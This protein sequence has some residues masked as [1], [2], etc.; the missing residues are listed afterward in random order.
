MIG[1]CLQQLHLLPIIILSNSFSAHCMQ[2][3]V[4][5]LKLVMGE[6][7]EENKTLK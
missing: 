6:K 2:L 5:I 4:L 7:D 1:Q 3:A